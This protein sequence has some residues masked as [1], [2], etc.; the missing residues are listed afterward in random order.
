MHAAGLPGSTMY[1]CDW[2]GLVVLIVVLSG[3]PLD[4]A[5]S[6][7]NILNV[8]PNWNPPSL[9]SGSVVFG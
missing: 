9:S 8:D 3:M 1:R 5:A 6:M 4:S 2:Y 7:V